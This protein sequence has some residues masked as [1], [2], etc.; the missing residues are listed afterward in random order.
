MMLDWFAFIQLPQASMPRARSFSSI[1]A[2]A[3][4]AAV[5]DPM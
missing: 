1:T 4:S 2:A 5:A 3:F